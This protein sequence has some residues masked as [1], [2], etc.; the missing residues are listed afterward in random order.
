M[1]NFAFAP[2]LRKS[3]LR[4]G[5]QGLQQLARAWAALQDKTAAS[6][7]SRIEWA[8]AYLESYAQ[9]HPERVKLAVLESDGELAAVI[10]LLQRRTLGLPYL[11]M[12]GSHELY[13]PTELLYRDPKSLAQLLDAVLRETGQPLVF[14]RHPGNAASIDIITQQLRQAWK[15]RR[16]QRPA[17]PSVQIGEDPEQVLNSG[18]RSDLRRML[19][20][21]EKYGKVTFRVHAPTL[22][23]LQPLFDAAM[24]IE[25]AGWKGETQTAL[26]TDVV[27]RS[28]F[29]RYARLTAQAGILRIAFMDIDGKPVASQINVECGGAIWLFRIGYDEAFADC[30]PGNLLMMEVIRYASRQKL[31]SCEFLGKAEGWTRM[32]T[33]NQYTTECITLFPGR[34]SYLRHMGVLAVEKLHEMMNKKSFEKPD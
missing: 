11:E 33:N 19:R 20:R 9:E 4:P 6:P 2:A 34:L 28:F 15:V 1:K 32:W 29:E 25:A 8:Q 17:S 21:A 5:P 16:R 24:K 3:V 7:M 12:L 23:E 18:R 22:D 31:K 30:S 26:Q 13:E 10:P 27:A 14:E